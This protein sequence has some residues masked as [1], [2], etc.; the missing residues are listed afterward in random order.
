MFNCLAAK[1]YGSNTDQNADGHVCT[2]YYILV[3]T[4]ALR[5]LEGGLEVTPL[6]CSVSVSGELLECNSIIRVVEFCS[7]YR[8]K[9]TSKITLVQ[10]GTCRAGAR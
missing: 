8:F 2:F 5:D 3:H 6:Q 7:G 1:V 4:H 10:T 9:L